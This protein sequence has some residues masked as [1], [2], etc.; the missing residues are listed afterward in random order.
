MILK[1]INIAYVRHRVESA[2]LTY[3]GLM[4]HENDYMYSPWYVIIPACPHLEQSCFARTKWIATEEIHAMK[5][6]TQGWKLEKYAW[7]RYLLP[8]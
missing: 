3:M 4:N 1:S 2:R 6:P 5:Q 8:R 7:G